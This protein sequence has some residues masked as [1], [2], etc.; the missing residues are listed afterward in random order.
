MQTQNK[1]KL[2]LKKLFLFFLL[3]SFLGTI[4]ETILWYFKNG[5]FTIHQEVLFLPLIPTYGIV[6]VILSC[7]AQKKRKW[8]QAILFSTLIG[9]FCEYFFSLGYEVFFGIKFWDYSNL[10]LNIN[11]RT[12]ILFA[13]FW[14]VLGAFFIHVVFPFL[15]SIFKKIPQ[16]LETFL[17]SFLCPFVFFS[18]F[19]TYTAL[20]RM[21]LKEKGLDDSSLIGQFYDQF[22]SSEFLFQHLHLMQKVSS[23]PKIKWNGEKLIGHAFY[24]VEEDTYTSSKE[25][26]L[27]GY[28]NGL[29]TF[30][31]DFQF[32]KDNELVL[33]HDWS[34]FPE[35]QG[36][37]PTLNE[38]VQN[39]IRGKYTPVTYRDLLN[40]MATYPDIWI[41]TDSKYTDTDSVTKEFQYLK[42]VAE[43]MGLSSLLDRFI[44]QIYNEDMYDVILEIYPFQNFIFTVY[45]VFQENMTTGRPFSSEDDERFQQ[46]CL[47]SKKHNISY[48]TFP[49]EFYDEQIQNIIVENDLQLFLHTE[50]DESK[51]K[52]YFKEGVSGIYTDSLSYQKIT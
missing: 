33:V 38:F 16:K 52:E 29:R 20:G 7:F 6:T 21:H 48:I 13:F 28:Q 9:S 35:F 42:N 31:V 24:I 8:W 30:E 2:G 5:V 14:G 23:F 19:F 37:A 47:W 41:I 43:E 45:Q 50:N 27:N 17:V 3:G 11:G 4:Y 1:Q 18:L 34:L 44:I 49:K 32:T 15:L 39:K 46:I 22:F 12:T 40:I 10:P 26:F 51:A 25:A 36:I